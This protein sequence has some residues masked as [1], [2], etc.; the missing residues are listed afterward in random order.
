MGTLLIYVVK[1]AVVMAVFY[2]FY[3]VLL[4][5]ESFIRVNRAVLVATSLAAFVLPL[6]VITLTKTIFIELPSEPL[7]TTLEQSTTLGTLQYTAQTEEAINEPINWWTVGVIAYALG[8]F[9]VLYHTIY[10]IIAV[11][12]LIS[13]AQRVASDNNSKLYVT[14]QPIA[15]FSWFNSVVI[16]A[17]DYKNEEERDVILAHERSH[18]A[19]KHSYDLLAANLCCAVQWFNP[20]AWMLREDLKEIHEFEADRTVIQSGHN[21][22]QYQLLLIKKAIG[23]KSYSTTNSLNHS[24]LKNRITMM[25]KRKS[26]VKSL[27]KL[28]YIVPLVGLSLVAFSRT[29]TVTEYLET[30]SQDKVTQNPQ[31]DQIPNFK[32]KLVGGDKSTENGREVD[33]YRVAGDFGERTHPTTGKL[34]LHTGIDFALKE[35]TPVYAVANGVV[36]SAK[37]DGGKGNSIVVEHIGGY[38]SEYSHLSKMSVKEG[39]AVKVEQQIGE[40]G[41]TGLAT[42]THLHLEIRKDGTPVDPMPLLVPAKNKSKS[43]A[44]SDKKQTMILSAVEIRIPIK[45]DS[46][47]NYY[48]GSKNCGSDLS[49]FE[50]ALREKIK[51]FD[52][53]IVADLDIA[54]KAKMGAVT[55][56]KQILRE[57][58]IVKVRYGSTSKGAQS[59]IENDEVSPKTIKGKRIDIKISGNGLILVDGKRQNVEDLETVFNSYTPKSDYVVT[60]QADRAADM[61]AFNE[62]IKQLNK[63]DLKQI[64]ELNPTQLRQK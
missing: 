58:G 5:K 39:D 20:T 35:G 21:A 53:N 32:F 7:K 11:R 9:A 59:T 63:A 31:N 44:S 17:N 24:T 50:A 43:S 34:A 42:G 48:V 12:L 64:V 6:C 47:S 15:P 25:L 60:I 28:L 61:E 38:E 55:D 51:G 3:R 41:K 27:A 49:A 40:V 33:V 16:S 1:V 19:L 52:G 45:L 30:K 37:Q 10:S 46:E 4:R 18:I 2:V 22:R 36:K 29:V 26:S 54:P 57:V 23:S 13:K 8:V 14:D 56:L 62:I